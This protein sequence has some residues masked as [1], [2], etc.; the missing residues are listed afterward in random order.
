MMCIKNRK[1]LNQITR[2]LSFSCH[3]KIAEAISSSDVTALNIWNAIADLA[4]DAATMSPLESLFEVR[5]LQEH[6]VVHQKNDY[7]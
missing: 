3:H 7:A 5:R 4:L 1:H 2:C 6:Q